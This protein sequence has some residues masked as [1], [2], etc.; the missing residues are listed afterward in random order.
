MTIAVSPFE[1]AHEPA[2][3][4][5]NARM[6]EGLAP[7]TF[8]LPERAK[9]PVQN[10][11]VTVTH[12]V[13]L[14]QD[15][16]VR[17]GI[18]LL[19]H[20]ALTAGKIERVV[21]IQAPLSEGII[22]PA[23]TFVGPQLIKH[24]LRQSPYAFVVGMGGAGNPL[25][26][27]LKAMGWT[28][29][30]VPFYFRMLDASR[31]VRN[32]APLRNTSIKRLGGAIAAATGAAAA[33]AMLAHRASKA[34]TDAAAEFE[35][36]P[37]EGWSSS[38]DD[39]W[40]AFKGHLGFAVLRTTGT[41]PFFYPFSGAGPKA[42]WLT[43]RGRVE[44]WFGLLIAPM[45]NNP[46]FGNLTVATLTDCVGSAQAVRAGVALAAA[47]ARAAGADLVITNQQHRQLQAACIE[48]GWRA[49]PSNYLLA[50]SRALSAVLTPE[51]AYVTR[52]DGDG[53][54]N[55]SG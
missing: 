35:A 17:G 1:H 47:R 36:M 7:S 28:I 8:L 45:A 55:L 53:L 13:A 3:A 32:L 6:R 9:P 25:P 4:A 12:H 52:R 42:W 43:R 26:R 30:T 21:N 10:G 2:A 37:V 11:S 23:F 34:S 31:C 44:G 33:G 51:T 54:T 22:D 29:N 39:A 50:T 38:A 18:M 5:F 46:Y 19:E 48:A 40:D 41:L 27:L 14:D 20:P 49:A 24:A 15:G 16:A